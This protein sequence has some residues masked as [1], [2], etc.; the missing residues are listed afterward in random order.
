MPFAALCGRGVLRLKVL[1]VEKGG[2]VFAVI[3]FLSDFCKRERVSRSRGSGCKK[4]ENDI[5]RQ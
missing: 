1:E 5:S 4:G 2:I 3:D